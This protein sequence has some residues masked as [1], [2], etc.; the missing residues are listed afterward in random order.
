MFDVITFSVKRKKNAAVKKKLSCFTRFLLDK[1]IILYELLKK[2][3]YIKQN[4]FSYCK[5]EL[6]IA[7]ETILMNYFNDLGVKLKR[8]F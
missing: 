2:C 8:N 6:K 7:M 5:L 3:R 1:D 4:Y